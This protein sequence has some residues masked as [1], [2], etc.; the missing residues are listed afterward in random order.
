[1]EEREKRRENK[2]GV[3]SCAG[4]RRKKQ[5]ARADLVLN[6]SITETVCGPLSS[7]LDLVCIATFLPPA[8]IFPE[9][10]LSRGNFPFAPNPILLKPN[11]LLSMLI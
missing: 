3:T 9:R 2:L 8:A 5:C 4:L 1:V 7:F 6:R 10:A 11:R